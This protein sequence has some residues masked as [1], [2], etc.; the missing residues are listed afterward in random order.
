MTHPAFVDPPREFD[1]CPFWFWNDDLD[2]R[3]IARQMADFQDH[4]VHAFVL[5]PRVG[6]PRS[7]PWM[8]D[9]MGRFVRFAVEEA[10]LRGMRVVLYDEGMYPSGSSS[11]QVVAENPEFRCRGLERR[12]RPYASA[13]V[14]REEGSRQDAKTPRVVYEDATW[15]VVERPIDATIR[16]LHYVGEGPEEDAP[17]AADLLNPDAVRCFIRLVHDRFREWVGHR[18][19]T[20][21]VGVFTD[22]PSLLG[23][24]RESGLL[25]GTRD[26]LDH[27]PRLVGADLRDRLPELWDAGSEA[28]RLYDRAVRLRLEETYYGP[29]SEWCQAHGLALMGHPEPPD[30]P[31][32][33]RFFDV[34]GQDLVWRWVLPGPTAL[35]G[36]QS[37]QAKAAASVAK[38]RGRRRNSN[39]LCGAYG[40]GLTF[41]EFKW[42]I[43]WC[44]VRGTNLFFPH[45]FYYSMRGP[46]R[47]ERPPDV[48]PN[49]PWWDG[50]EVF[51]RYCARLCWL[52]TD[53]EHVCSVAVLEREGRFPWEPAKAL[54][55]SQVDFDYLALRDLDEWGPRYR[56]VID[57][58]VPPGLP[59][60]LGVEPHPD[61]RVRHVRKVGCDLYL[62][63]NENAE[64]LD[65]ALEGAFTK[66]DPMTLAAAPTEGRL[67]MAPFEMVVL[68]R[69]ET[70]AL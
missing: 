41:A 52:N 35:E 30:D 38:H 59:R 18:F 13:P 47:D 53:S 11:G 10:A 20:T 45:A 46:R 56:F 55:Q 27:V 68:S 65:L 8:S 17:P 32:P 14:R 16:G 43:D 58:D 25:P 44:A 51:A 12:P 70:Q 67:R 48:G 37:V 33:L 2:E 63:H 24:P 28:C 23:R 6:L 62:V 22:E 26:I 1:L 15:T 4:G 69:D 9:A 7:I 21:V 29:L 19:G 31:S 34:P 60:S 40:H 39:E 36:P 57:G 49:S 3:E 66:I 64:A 54:F 42:L 5:H 61:L 50:F